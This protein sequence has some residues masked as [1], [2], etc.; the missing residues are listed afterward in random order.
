[1]LVTVQNCIP[2]D[3]MS[4][5]VVRVLL[6]CNFKPISPTQLSTE[7]YDLSFLSDSF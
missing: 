6:S 5:G 2:P 4:F 7:I 3:R 1:M